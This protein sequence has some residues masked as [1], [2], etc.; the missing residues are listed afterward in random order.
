MTS[1]GDNC[2][3]APPTRYPPAM[4]PEPLVEEHHHSVG[5]YR[6]DTAF[7]AAVGPFLAGGFAGDETVVVVA[8]AVHQAQL[9]R[10]LAGLGH[11]VADLRSTGRYVSFDARQMLAR[12]MIG[13]RP[14]PERFER[15]LGSVVVAL[16]GDPRPLRIFGEMVGVL[17]A[18]GNVTGAVQ[19]EDIWN[20][21]RHRA[22]FQLHCGYDIEG[23]E[24]DL[25]ALHQVCGAHSR[26]T[27]PTWSGAEVLGQDERVTVFL[28][29]AQTLA[30]VRQFVR[31]TLADWELGAFA[32]DAQLAAS[33]LATNAVAHASSP[34]EVSLRR[35]AGTFTLR[36]R[37]ANPARP[38]PRDPSVDVPGGRGLGLVAAL[39]A[40]WG[41]DAEGGGKAVW[42][43][44]DTAG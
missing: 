27:T 43:T 44:F 21:L 13:G 26:L 24:A 19:L 1:H 16:A 18:E 31:R 37:D 41:V 35:S 25:D 17:W 20:D 29:S 2:R 9:D 3:R 42:A 30:A 34:F 6:D 11:D 12:F 10:V 38:Q 36:V 7:A 23:P 40:A 22:P 32:G 28:P 15:A 14:D 39:A 33:E 4:L 5:F 8:T